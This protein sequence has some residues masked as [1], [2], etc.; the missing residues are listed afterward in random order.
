MRNTI[1]VITVPHSF[2]PISAFSA[3]DKLYIYTLRFSVSTT[4]GEVQR[5][6]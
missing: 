1:L 5:I 3:D 6:E 2:S 4:L